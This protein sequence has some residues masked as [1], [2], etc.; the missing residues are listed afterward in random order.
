VS[1]LH[2]FP[3]N[4]GDGA[5]PLGDLIFNGMHNLYSTAQYGGADNA[6]A[7]FEVTP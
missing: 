5:Y 6:G 3:D 2:K 4:N 7:V 1:L